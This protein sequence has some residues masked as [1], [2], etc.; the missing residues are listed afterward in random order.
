M[1]NRVFLLLVIFVVV[2]SAVP[3]L[4]QVDRISPVDARFMVG[5]GEALLICGYEDVEK[6]AEM[7]LEGSIDRATLEKVEKAL[8]QE[9]TLIFY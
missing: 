2:L 5:A 3:A 1:R 8:K 7:R 4:A 9:F 6:C